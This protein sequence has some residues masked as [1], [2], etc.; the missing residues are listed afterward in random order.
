MDNISDFLKTA[1]R[2]AEEREKTQDEIKDN[3]LE[4]LKMIAGVGHIV[5]KVN[6]DIQKTVIGE[7]QATKEISQKIKGETLAI[8]EAAESI[9]EDTRETKTTTDESRVVLL[10]VQSTL[11]NLPYG[12]HSKDTTKTL[13]KAI[14][15][16][17][18]LGLICTAALGYKL[19]SST[20][21]FNS[22]PDS[23]SASAEVDIQ[24][25]EEYKRNLKNLA[26]KDNRL[27]LISTR[28]EKWF[29]LHEL[30]R[31]VRSEASAQ[32]II[33][34][35]DSLNP[36]DKLKCTELHPCEL[37]SK[38][39]YETCKISA[40]LNTQ[41]KKS[42]SM[43][44]SSVQADLQKTD[45]VKPSMIVIQFRGSSDLR[46]PNGCRYTSEEKS[47]LEILQGKGQVDNITIA[48]ARA[49]SLRIAVSNTPEY[50]KL[51]DPE[52]MVSIS[53]GSETEL[54]NCKITDKT[55][56][57]HEKHRFARIVAYV[58]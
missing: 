41:Q 28:H 49:N 57:C 19:H 26:K 27:E 5:N 17:G 24:S 52:S 15:G 25:G 53:V 29:A 54:G 35:I 8:K 30:K 44:L 16:V 11:S 45:S 32:R 51:R 21:S 23:L 43:S 40:S 34:H 33:D 6:C 22:L 3:T 48:L 10:D 58:R 14:F 1:I 39:T 18:I 13:Y 9:K 36:T 38:Y 55:D 4:T 7:L 2:D 47:H 46:S 56:E 12:P 20:R 42:I 37:F 31:T 50:Q